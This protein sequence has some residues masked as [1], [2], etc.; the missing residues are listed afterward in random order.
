MTSIT[1]PS[2]PTP[3]LLPGHHRA[4]PNPARCAFDLSWGRKEPSTEE[5][6]GRS[7]A[8][9]SP[10]MSGSPPLPLRSA[11]EAGS[12]GEAPSY[13]APRLLD[14]L[15]GGPAQAPPTS[16]RDQ[17]S[18]ITRSYPPEPATRSPYSYPRPEDAGR[19]Y[20]Y[21]PQHHHGM[22]QGASA[23]P[24]LNSASSEPYPAPDRSQAADTQSLT[25][26]KSQRKTKGHVASACVPCKK[27]HLR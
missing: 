6:A 14:G 5:S 17:T 2:N 3:P 7:R 15:R 10:P 12:R 21:P 26:P 22:P 20:V 13:Y 11:H 19:I 27:A 18:P 9:P 25:S 4:Y 16:N 23:A 1:H 8:Y 24:Y